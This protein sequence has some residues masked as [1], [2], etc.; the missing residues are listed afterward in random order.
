MFDSH[1][2]NSGTGGK[3]REGSSNRNPS[4]YLG[5]YAGPKLKR[6]TPFEPAKIG[7][8]NDQYMKP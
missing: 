2:N 3:S 4:S 8:E 1:K 5:A 7:N 6:Y